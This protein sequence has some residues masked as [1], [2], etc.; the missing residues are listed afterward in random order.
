MKIIVFSD[1]H[2]NKE[3]ILSI[4]D[5]NKN[6]DYIISLGDS[7]LPQG[8]FESRNII[9]IRGNAYFDGGNYYNHVLSINNRKI[10]LT[11]G[12][13]FHVRS[14][15][16]QLVNK[17]KLEGC[18]IALYGHTHIPKISKIDGIYIVNPGALKK[19]RLHNTPTYL[20][21]DLK[22]ADV[23]FTHKH[24]ITNEVIDIKR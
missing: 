13:L 23:Q 7:E 10:F 19:D 12:H 14:T 4:L 2:G 15:F 17:A 24:A 21:I 16:T 8:F 18:T 1:A 3:I 6:A 5:Q 20:E 9:S 22:E 11:H